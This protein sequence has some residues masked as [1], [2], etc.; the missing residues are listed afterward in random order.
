[1]ARKG[2]TP[3]FGRIGA[4]HSPKLVG[5]KLPLMPSNKKKSKYR[6]SKRPAATSTKKTARSKRLVETKTP[7]R[8]AKK[9][10]AQKKTALKASGNRKRRASITT[11]RDIQ[12]EIQAKKRH[13]DVNPEICKVCRERSKRTRK[14]LTNWSKKVT[15]LRPVLWQV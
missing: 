14:A 15:S 6:K 3:D 12:R 4:A 8:L 1:M 11:E 9:R 2:A 7:K 10:T 5:D 13:L